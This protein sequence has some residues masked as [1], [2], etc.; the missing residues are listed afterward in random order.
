MTNMYFLQ[1]QWE[2]RV[3]NKMRQRVVVA[4]AVIL[5]SACGT[6]PKEVIIRDATGQVDTPMKASHEEVGSGSVHGA[7]VNNKTQAP[8]NSKNNTSPVVSVQPVS[9]ETIRPSSPLQQKILQSAQ[10]KI[11]AKDSEGAIVLA[12]KGLRIDRKDPQ[13]YIVLARAY[14]QLGD[15][16]QS[17]YFARQGLR[18]VRKGSAEYQTLKRLAS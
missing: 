4:S 13:F 1:K 2:S 11:A 18:Y 14:K 10:Q 12:E 6:S 16:Q 9:P 15:K 8:S 7:A 3:I 5:L 17:S